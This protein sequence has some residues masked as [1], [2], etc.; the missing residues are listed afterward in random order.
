MSI[1]SRPITEI[2]K[3]AVD[4][5]VSRIL[6]FSDI[7]RKQGILAVIPH[8][9]KKAAE[10]RNN[11][12]EYGLAMVCS[13]YNADDLEDI[14]QNIYNLKDQ[15]HIQKLTDTLYIIG[16]LAIQRGDNKDILVQRLDSRIP[17]QY[18][19]DQL[20]KCITEISLHLVNEE[21]FPRVYLHPEETVME[22]EKIATLTDKQIQMIMREVDTDTLAWAICDNERMKGVFYHNMS[23]RAPDM[24]ETDI[25]YIREG[26]TKLAQNEIIRIAEKMGF[27]EG[28]DEQ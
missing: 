23:S 3:G 19:S 1:D 25:E 2:A 8:L 5:T 7:S 21:E 26:R 10:D 18:R 27:I 17:E 15:D 11:L 22:F 6:S 14:L 28:T 12:L 24:L 20:R 16:V 13:G 4:I 9:D